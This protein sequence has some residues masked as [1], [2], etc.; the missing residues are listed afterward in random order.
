MDFYPLASFTPF[1]V[2]KE[3]LGIYQTE[4]ATAITEER[5]MLNWIRIK[6]LALVEEEDIEFYP[7]FNVVTGETGAGKSVIIGTM[8]LLLGERADKG[9]IR[10]GEDR[11]EI[12]ASITLEDRV[13]AEVYSVLDDAGITYDSDDPELFI[14]RVITQS[15]TRNFINDSSTTLQTLKVIGSK[16]IDIHGANEHHSLSRQGR[17]L[18]LLDKYGHLEKEKSKCRKLCDDIKVVILKR[19]A[20]NAELASPIEAEHLRL[21]VEEIENINPQPDEDKEL[22]AKHAVAANSKQVIE[23]TSESVNLLNESEHSVIDMLAELHRN[24]QQLEKIDSESA[25]VLVEQCDTLVEGARELAF[26]IERY[27]SSTELDEASFFELEERLSALQTLK[28]RYGPYMESVFESLEDAKAKL[29]QFEGSEEIR[30]L[31]DEEEAQLNKDLIAAANTLSKKRKKSASNF[32]SNVR[33]ELVKL[34]FLQA[35]F[36]IE[37]SKVDPGANGF[38]KIDFFFSPNPGERAQPL[39]NIA[40]S[41]EMS[42]IMLALKTVLAEADS[43]PILVFDEIDVNIGGETAIKVGEGLKKLAQSHQILCISHLPQVASQADRHYL[44]KKSVKD[45]RTTTYIKTLNEVEQAE[46]IGRMLGGG[47]AALNHAKDLLK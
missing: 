5:Y 19:E 10:T 11:C 17:Q 27:S 34:G 9:M 36:T 24:L 40:S 6:N 35:D 23:I 39:R 21:V 13:Q 33:K 30:T 3:L 47:E 2:K 4:L 8:G 32:D 14:R 31:L 1:Q 43:V 26:D 46:E 38:D 42:R 15:S 20:L 16:L 22:S 28:R 25:A 45:K 18:E 44:V 41:G 37:F 29:Q 7:G 12:S